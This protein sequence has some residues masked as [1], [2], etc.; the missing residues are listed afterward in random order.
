[1]TDS[2]FV[3]RE[4]E[5][6][7]LD[8]FLDRALAG[9][10]AVCFVAG[11]A[12]S[13]KT[14]LAGA[15]AR[16]AQERHQD[17]LVAVG[18]SDAE[19]GAGDPYL[20]FREV[21]GLLTGDVEADVER[22]TITAENANR[23]RNVLSLSIRALVEV[24][25]DLIG[26]F[27]P[28]AGLAMQLGAFA[29]EKVGWLEKLERR[30]KRSEE[31]QAPSSTGIDQDNIFE[32]YTNVLRAL[33]AERPLVLVLDD[34]QW[35]DAASIGLLF[36]LGRRIGDS[37][38][39]IVGT[40][41]PDEVALGRPSPGS[42]GNGRHPL[43]KVL[44]EFKRYHGDIV[45]DLAQAGEAAGRHF[46]DALLDMEPNRLD[47][48][49]RRALYHHTGGQA[50]FTVELLRDMQER[51]DVMRDEEGR[52]IAGPSLNWGALPVR[53]EGVIE[54]RIGRLAVDLRE[55]LTVASVE[56]ESFT[57][58]V[59][60]AVQDVSA[61]DLVRQLS[62]ELEKRH[63]LVQAQGVQ[64]LATGRQRLSRYAFQHNLFQRYLYNDLDEVER[65]ILHEDVG[66]VLEALYGDDLDE[67]T[68]QL[69]W[70]FV[71]AG[72]PEKAVAYLQRAGERAA[73]QFAN[74]E[75]VAHL[76]QALAL[77]PETDL[78][79]RYDLLLVREAVYGRQGDRGAQQ[80]DLAQLAELA[81]ALAA[82]PSSGAEL[83][84]AQVALRQAIYAEVTGDYPAA[85]A[86]AQETVRLAQASEDV[87]R[88]IAGSLYWGRAL[89]RQGDCEASRPQLERALAL[90][91]D[92]G[93]RQEEGDSQRN[94]G[95][96]FARQGEFAQAGDRLEQAL[97]IYRQIGDRPGESAAT[98]TLGT[99]SAMQ[100]DFC[101]A[102][103]YFAQAL[104]TYQETGDR[105]G[106][107]AL[108]GNLGQVSSEMGRYDQ[109]QDHF[110]QSLAICREID[111][112]QGEGAALNNLGAVCVDLGD[113]AQALDYF[114][115]AAR[116]L[117]E[118][119]NRQTEGH[120]LAGQGQ[121]HLRL[122][123]YA[124]AGDFLA[125]ALV[126]L[127][128][129][130][131]RQ[132]EGWALSHQA[133]LAHHLGDDEAARDHA[134]Q[135][136]QIARD[137]GDRATEAYALTNLGHALLGLGEAEAAGD[138]YRQAL[139]LRRELDQPNPA[140]EPQAG[141]ARALLAHGE[142]TL[143]Q[144]QVDEIL[145][146]V[147]AHTASTDAGT[148]LEGVVE[149][150]RVHLTCYYVLRAQSPEGDPR[151]DQ[152]RAAARRGLQTQAALIGD[153]GLRRAFLKAEGVAAHRGIL[154]GV[155]SMDSLEES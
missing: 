60:A 57:A 130:G 38:I 105:W 83:R 103:S 137:L 48:G 136:L 11:E 74:Q 54:E 134:Q 149:P 53:V 154:R 102:Q 92:A 25:P 39:L 116:I 112:L 87:A 106:E 27:V 98:N 108:L 95:I 58:E 20:P 124:A 76:N 50:L 85:I 31:G 36:R 122:G 133:L 141:L 47:Q 135:A 14:A 144:A 26:I 59:V 17:L 145:A 104:E 41:R 2:A 64:R 22:G 46:V 99:L 28:G 114:A 78:A 120:A 21:L 71:E 73:A 140:L 56:G 118:I 81:G 79:G 6:A 128:Q 30:I 86:A 93:L 33:A 52:W 126:V 9:Q 62:R 151:A 89:W 12:G 4:Q 29:A 69:A 42:D 84:R 110:A 5:L 63:R 109:A 101:Q 82:A 1:L 7:Q 40:Y 37:R 44:A 142:P 35:A 143:A 107:G 72:L 111:D 148:G 32:Q 15:F 150:Y 24:G 131:D 55:A 147:A 61:R 77:T 80:Q 119:G 67:I 23:L 10:G 96:V 132:G 90:A 117:G 155:A 43:E 66:Y 91:R 19:T 129:V 8:R 97:D 51:G 153:E 152:V 146:H 138:A 88:E 49:F 70:H 13:G 94:L 115:Q 100:G 18:Q 127:R 34:L 16:R 113:Y 75:A 65:S 45:V 68:V 125:Q 3:A 121:A 123:D 139:T